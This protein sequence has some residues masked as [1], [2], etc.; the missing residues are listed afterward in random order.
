MTKTMLSFTTHPSLQS[1]QPQQQHPHHPPSHHLLLLLLL[2]PC[3]LPVPCH[4][5]PLLLLV[6]LQIRRPVQRVRLPLC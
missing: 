3:H 6:L 2:L 4:P 5:V 1:Q